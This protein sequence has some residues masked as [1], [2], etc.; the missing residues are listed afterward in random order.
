MFGDP[1]SNPNSFVKKRLKDTCVIV[2]GNT[3]SRAVVEY[4][5]DYI[6]WIKTDNIVQGI[7]NPTTAVENLSEKGA[8]VGKIVEKNAIL[9]AC[10]AGSVA[11]IGKVCITDRAVAFNQQI[12]AILPKEYNVLFLYVL[13]Q[14]SNVYLVEDLNMALKGILSKSRLES[15]EFIVPPLDLQ[16]QFADFVVQVD[17]SKFMGCN[18]Y[19][20]IKQPL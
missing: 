4:Y 20:I 8:E 5:G 2:T 12:N 7:L 6:E 15:K 3:P 1:V 14:I 10:I 18:R 16:N 19:R 17:K 9:M 13:F 11:S